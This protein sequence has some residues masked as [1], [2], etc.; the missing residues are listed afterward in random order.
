MSTTTKSPKILVAGLQVHASIAPYFRTLYGT[1]SE[2]AAKISADTARIKSAGYDV[3]VYYMNDD[4]PQTGLAWLTEKLQ[5]E[6]F[7]GVMVGSGLRLVPEQTELFEKVMNVV[8][9][10]S[11]ESMLM[12]NDGPGGNYEALKRN[13][14]VLRGADYGLKG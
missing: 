3:T 1:P 13:E 5:A 9:R 4:D 2:I 12:F 6:K 8:R 11:P 7:D 14:E 10:V